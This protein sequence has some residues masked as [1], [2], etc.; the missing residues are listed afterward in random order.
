MSEQNS[1]NLSQFPRRIK[2]LTEKRLELIEKQS[3]IQSQRETLEGYVGNF[4]EKTAS[5]KE[6]EYGLLEHLDD[7]GKTAHAVVKEN[8]SG[9]RHA[10]QT[11]KECHATISTINTKIHQKKRVYGTIIVGITLIL[12]I[13]L[14]FF[15]SS[16][17]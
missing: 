13:G 1:E 16:S 3:S 7:E 8:I 4:D 9:M 12:L 14:Y 17:V 15:T 10:V 5:T 11:M 6:P 2:A